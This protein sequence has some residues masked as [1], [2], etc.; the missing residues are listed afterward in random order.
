MARPTPSE[1]L[2]R[3]GTALYGERTGWMKPLAEA[4]KYDPDSVERW[5]GKKVPKGRANIFPADHEAFERAQEL[6]A[7]RIA[8]LTSVAI[9]LKRWRRRSTC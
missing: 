5:V 2:T 3:I 6:L 9:A 8:E 7:S 4:L 1:M